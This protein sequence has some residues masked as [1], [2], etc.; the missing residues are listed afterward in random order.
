MPPKNYRKYTHE[1]FK[2]LLELASEVLVQI[3]K[4]Q[5]RCRIIRKE[6]ISENAEFVVKGM[7]KA[8]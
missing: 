7:N 5:Q 3:E 6:N 1:T 2:R 4:E 8:K